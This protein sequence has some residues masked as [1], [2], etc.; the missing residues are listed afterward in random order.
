MGMET[1]RPAPLPGVATAA[2]ALDCARNGFEALYMGGWI[3]ANELYA[4]PDIGLVGMERMVQ[5]AREISLGLSAHGFGG[6]PIL[7]DADTGYGD[8]K[9]VRLTTQMYE[10]AGVAAIHL[11]DQQSPKRCGNTAGKTI[12]SQEEF[13]QKIRSALDSRVDGDFSIVA[14]TDAMT[15]AYEAGTEPARVMDEIVEAERDG[16]AARRTEPME[17]AKLDRRWEEYYKSTTDESI[18]RLLAYAE[19]GADGLW[20]ESRGPAQIGQA[21]RLAKEVKSAHP[22]VPLIFNYSPSYLN[23]EKHQIGFRDLGRM[24][25]DAV[26]LTYWTYKRAHSAL[27]D[28]YRNFREK[29]EKT[30]WEL[31]RALKEHPLEN[32]QD[33]G[34]FKFWQ[35]FEEAHAPPQAFQQRYARSQ[36]H[37]ELGPADI[38]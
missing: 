23:W 14:R 10:Q 37:G 30:L 22:K 31:E 36:G 25:F 12:I 18:R 15:A 19:A 4:L 35:G 26:L 21:E 17:K 6:T 11:E 28:F 2:Q 1:R 8:V 29:G 3:V 27:F 7:A 33:Y 16:E 5:G 38:V 32:A 13:V 24:G 20:C 9:N 34:G